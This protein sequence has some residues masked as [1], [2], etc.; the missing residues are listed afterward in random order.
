M[1]LKACY[2]YCLFL[3]FTY[4]RSIMLIRQQCNRPLSLFTL[5]L[6]SLF[7]ICYKPYHLDPYV[8]FSCALSLQVD[9]IFIVLVYKLTLI[10]IT[11]LLQEKRLALYIF[12]FFESKCCLTIYQ[13]LLL[14]FPGSRIITENETWIEKNYIT[15]ESYFED[16]YKVNIIVLYSLYQEKWIEY[17]IML[18]KL[19][20]KNRCVYSR[21][22]DRLSPLHPGYTNERKIRVTRSTRYEFAND[23]Y[24]DGINARKRIK[25]DTDITRI[26][27][28]YDAKNDGSNYRSSTVQR[29]D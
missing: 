2:F 23:R 8:Q 1:Y 18:I 16:N 15:K 27:C 25:N 4:K 28:A 26:L 22:L 5:F 10:Q 11:R 24:A 13:P 17:K 12:L 3:R 7:K 29:N 14:L 6:F 9:M 19:M 21:Q 20:Q